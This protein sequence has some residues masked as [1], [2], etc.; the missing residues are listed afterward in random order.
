LGV[1]KRIVDLAGGSGG[2]GGG[3][4][5]SIALRYPTGVEQLSATLGAIES[6]RLPAFAFYCVLLYTHDEGLD[7]SLHRYVRARF[8]SL[9]DLSGPNWLLFV[10]ADIG[11]PRQMA[12]PP[13]DVYAIARFLGTRMDAIPC[14]VFFGDPGNDRRTLVVRMHDFLPQT[15]AASSEPMTRAFRCLTTAVDLAVANGH[16]SDLTRLRSEIVIAHRRVF[17]ELAAR[18]GAS[19]RGVKDALATGKSVLETVAAAASLLTAL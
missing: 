2:G 9:D 6:G 7:R 1:A 13:E 10:L 14:A 3:G 18:R 12:S 4:G 19:G 11:L 16:A 8:R 15:A 17:P 5:R